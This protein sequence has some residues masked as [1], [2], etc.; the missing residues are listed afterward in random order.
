MEFNTKVMY[1]CNSFFAAKT[2]LTIVEKEGYVWM[3]GEKP[4]KYTHYNYSK[5]CIY[6]GVQNDG[7]IFYRDTW[8]LPVD[9]YVV[10]FNPNVVNSI[11]Y[12]LRKNGV[13]WIKAI[14]S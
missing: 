6:Y 8:D 7:R 10:G 11:E 13:Q 9:R 5:K 1:K 14:E 2:F 3:T 12:Y 4:T